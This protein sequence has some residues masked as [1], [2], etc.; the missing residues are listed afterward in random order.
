MHVPP[1]YA[2]FIPSAHPQGGRPA[3]RRRRPVQGPAA[4]RAGAGRGP[5]RPRRRRARPDRRR[6]LRRQ[7]ARRRRPT[8]SACAC[9]A[10]RSASGRMGLNRWLGC[11]ENPRTGREAERRR[12]APP[13]AGAAAGGRG[14]RRAR[15]GCRPR[16][17][18]PAAATTST[19]SSASDQPGGQVAAG[20]DGAEPGRVRRHRA[21][22]GA[23]VPARSASTIDY[24]VGVD[25]AAV[26]GERARRRRRRHRRRAR[27]GRGGRRP[28]P[29][30][31]V[32][33]RDVLDGAAAPDGR[34]VV[35]R[36]ARLPPGHV[37]GRAAG[38]PRLRGRGRHPGMVVGQ[39]LGITLDLE[40]WDMR[41]AA[42]G[43]AQTHRPGADG[44]CDGDGTLHA[45][46]PPDRPN[47]DRTR[48]LGRAGRPANSRSSGSTTS[49]DASPGVERRTASAT[50]SRRGGPTPR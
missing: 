11:I 47:V 48:R 8:T 21:Q 10:T 39:D 7:G 42:K 37:G 17:P 15:P 13:V 22:P 16:S 41:A 44:R 28:T 33:V 6:R 18:R 32:D 12:S 9:R 24:G 1:G 5:L 29:T 35:D 49:C 46:A 30:T 31:V 20:G 19:V 45:A 3:G 27:P 25:A 4:G 2:L 43:I 26:A 14:R 38:R 40:N 23:R 34:V 50:A 36:R